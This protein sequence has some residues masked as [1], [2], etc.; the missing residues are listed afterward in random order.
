M[1]LP[2]SFQYFVVGAVLLVGAGGLT[3]YVGNK[4]LQDASNISQETPLQTYQTADGNDCNIAVID[5]TG[6]LW[7]SKAD[8]DAQTATDNSDNISAEE[9]L[10]DL[11]QAKDDGSILGVVLRVDSGGGSPVGGELIAN[12]LK[13]LGKPSVALIEDEGDSA[14]YLAS[15]G[16]NVIIASPFSDVADIGIT[17]SYLDQAGSDSQS[18]EKFIAVAAGQYKDVGNPDAPVTP[19]DQAYLQGLVNGD[20]QTFI[21]EVAQNRSMSVASVQALA[22]GDSLTGAMAMGTGLIDKLGDASTAQQWFTGKLGKGSG[23]VLCD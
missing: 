11:E 10:G 18:G 22:N 12:A 19:A 3:Y 20:Y 21:K 23:P 7:A 9:I 6:Q 5:L 14:A 4:L 17:S 2:T 1:R 8:A 16:A 15:T 13:S